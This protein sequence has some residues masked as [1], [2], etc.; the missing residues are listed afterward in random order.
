[1]RSVSVFDAEQFDAEFIG[2]ALRNSPQLCT[3]MGEIDLEGARFDPGKIFMSKAAHNRLGDTWGSHLEAH[4]RCE[5]PDEMDD[6]SKADNDLAVQEHS[7][8]YNIG[9]DLVIITYIGEDTI[10]LMR[11]EY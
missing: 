11:E 2:M 8:V 10:I 6:E 9:R 7:G 1:M 5:W 4:L 3:C